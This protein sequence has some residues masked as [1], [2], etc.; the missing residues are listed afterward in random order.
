MNLANHPDWINVSPDKKAAALIKYV[1]TQPP[2]NIIIRN[3]QKLFKISLEGLRNV[4]ITKYGIIT[5]EQENLLL[6]QLGQYLLENKVFEKV[7]L[8]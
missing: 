8:I 4:L 3:I 7:V 5:E 1:L 2:N 6:Q